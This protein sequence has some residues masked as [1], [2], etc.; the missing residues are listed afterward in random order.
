MPRVVAE[1][2]RG[3]SELVRRLRRWTTA[4]WAVPAS[5]PVVPGLAPPATIPGT[6]TRADVTWLAV[7][8]LADL[9]ATV[10][11]RPRRP[12][13]RLADHTLP[14]QLVVVWYDIAHTADPVAVAAAQG[15]LTTLHA[16][17]GLR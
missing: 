17:L 4:S 13:P 11:R 7:Q 16:S 5:A 2:T 10:D 9:A 8:Q 12:V 14:D 3:V 6:A 15:I 1:T